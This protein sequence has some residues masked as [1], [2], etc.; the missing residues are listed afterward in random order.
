MIFST[1]QIM[2]VLQCK[3]NIGLFIEKKTPTLFTSSIDISTNEQENCLGLWTS[4]A[5]AISPKL[6]V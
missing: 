6:N 4:K 3:T 2:I 5:Y 1:A